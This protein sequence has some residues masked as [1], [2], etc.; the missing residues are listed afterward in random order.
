MWKL[1]RGIQWLVFLKYPFQRVWSSLL[2]WNIFHLRIFQ[3]TK[4]FR[5]M[6]LIVIQKELLFLVKNF[7]F[8]NC[9]L[10][11]GNCPIFCLKKKKKSVE[12]YRHIVF[13]WMGCWK[14][15]ILSLFHSWRLQAAW[16]SMEAVFWAWDANQPPCECYKTR[17]S[18]S[19]PL[20]HNLI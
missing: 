19:I 15:E 8:G 2:D 6:I 13:N 11:I 17:N 9:I 18:W 16:L 14:Q 20:K 1:R 3:F 10:H 12:K 7:F 5:S 4:M